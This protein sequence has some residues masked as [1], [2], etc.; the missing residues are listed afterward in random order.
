MADSN[1]KPKH[2]RALALRANFY[3]GSARLLI[4]L[5]ME[6]EPPPALA[7]SLRSIQIDVLAAQDCVRSIA[8]VA[9]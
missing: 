8:G 4:D 6:A 5:A 2:W 1:D 7:A 3:L 9:P